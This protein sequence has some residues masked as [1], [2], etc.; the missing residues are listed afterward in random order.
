[1]CLNPNLVRSRL[2]S[3]SGAVVTTFLGKAGYVDPH[4]FGEPFVD[5]EWFTTVPCGQ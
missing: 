5:H 2:D 3:E 1:M 4:D